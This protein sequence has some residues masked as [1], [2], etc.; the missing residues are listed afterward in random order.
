MT[1]LENLTSRFVKLR[2][3][4]PVSPLTLTALVLVFIFCVDNATFW[5]LG[6]QI[7]V[8][9]VISFSAYILAVFLLM[10]GVF[11]I[12]AFPWVVKPFLAFMVILSAVTSYY[13]D[14]LGVVIDRD[15]IQ[16]VMVTT[17]TESK[18]LITV[19]F[20][21]H[22]LVYGVLPALVV[23]A[24]KLKSRSVIRTVLTPVLSFV[25]CLALM[26]GLLMADMKSYSSI[27]RERK[28]FMSSFQPGM[29]IIGAIRYAKMMRKTS[30][31][32]MAKIGEDA[33]KGPSYAGKDKPVLTIL[34]AGETARSQNFSLNGYGVDTNPE[35]AKR[36]IVSFSDVS[37]C[38]TATAVSLPCMFSKFSRD[39]YSFEKGV[40]NEDVLDVVTH[41]GLHVEWWDNNTGDKGI[42]GRIPSR[43][44]TNTKN[45]EFC[46]A[47]ECIDGIFMQSLADYADTIT[48][49]TVLVLHQIGSHGPTYYLRYPEEFEKFKPA[50]R[51]AEFKNCTPEEITNAYDNTIAYTDKIL[52]DTIDFLESRDNLVTAMIYMSDHGESLGE[53]GMYLH[54]SPY[55]M[56]PEYQTKVP[57]ILWMSSAFQDQF[58]I[59]Q[60]CLAE[61]KDAALSHDNLF[62]SLLGMLDIHT[63]ER[64]EA[65]DI[66]ASCKT[67]LVGLNN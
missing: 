20:V 32:T 1:H 9:H 62:H 4:W 34:V 31:V 2:N 53:S 59:D 26:A 46:A 13:M 51:T 12:F 7:F 3:D 47:G 11:S 21:L 24:F 14:N 15:M 35:L 17:V 30:N 38:G 67:A 55:F 29:P 52:A 8:G 56:A 49:D 40:S 27:L 42:A 43:S 19:D 16:N 45:D 48:Q 25:V 54:G 65:L 61:K 33:T 41:A 10:L 50:C 18:H 23:F 60:S 57:A 22:N 39:T 5:S 36:S 6:S 63:A 64:N 66:F 58:G 44:F 28:D 37:S